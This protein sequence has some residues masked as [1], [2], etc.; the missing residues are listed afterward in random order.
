MAKI[1]LGTIVGQISGSAGAT[2]F[3]HGRFGAYIRLRSI[4]VQPDSPRQL[5]RR[6]AM[7][8]NSAA[9]GLLIPT[10]RLAWKV[11][12]EN[13]PITDRLGDKRILSGHQAYVGLNSRLDVIGA[14]NISS[15]PVKPGPDALTA[16]SMTASVAT[17]AA[18]L[19]YTATPIGAGKCLWINGAKTPTATVNYIKNLL[20]FI[21]YSATAQASPYQVDYFAIKLGALTLGECLIANCH[22]FD[23]ATG[24][25]SPPLQARCTVAA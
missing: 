18:I 19:T 23:T 24:L 9:W 1:R 25:L 17:Q 5:A 15:P 10:V 6:A 2:T 8:G 20:R 11:W 12:A 3:S 7:G 14:A 21:E 22:V 13:N 4:P 16:V